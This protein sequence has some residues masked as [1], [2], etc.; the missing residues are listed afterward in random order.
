MQL[1]H[2]FWPVSAYVRGAKLHQSILSSFWQQS[3]DLALTAPQLPHD[4]GSA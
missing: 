3:F 2:V 1:L 4:A